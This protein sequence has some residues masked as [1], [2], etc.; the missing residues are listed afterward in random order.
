MVADYISVGFGTGKAFPVFAVAQAP[1]G[2]LLHQ[3]IYTTTAGQ[4][5]PQNEEEL[6]SAEGDRPVPNAHSDHGPR[7]YLDQD[8]QIPVSGKKPPARD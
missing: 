6:L 4:A 8:N 1:T 2:S 5:L 7:E 3:A